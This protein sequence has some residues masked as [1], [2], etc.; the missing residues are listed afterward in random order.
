[1]KIKLFLLISLIF[2]C[3]FSGKIYA[4]ELL[5]NDDEVWVMKVASDKTFTWASF[6]N[7]KACAVANNITVSANGTYNIS[8]VGDVVL[9]Y[10][11]VSNQ[12]AIKPQIAVWVSQYDKDGIKFSA[13]YIHWRYDLYGH[14]YFLS[15]PADLLSFT[16]HPSDYADFYYLML[17]AN[18][19]VDVA[20]PSDSPI[21]VSTLSKIQHMV[22]A[23]RRAYGLDIFT[24]LPARSWQSGTAV[25]GGQWLQYGDKNYNY[26]IARVDISAAKNTV[27]PNTSAA[28]RPQQQ[29]R[30]RPEWDDDD[31][32]ITRTY[33]SG[34]WA[35]SN[36]VTM[37]VLQPVFNYIPRY[38]YISIEYKT[39]KWY[40]A[41]I[42]DKVYNSENGKMV[43]LVD[44]YEAKGD[45]TINSIVSIKL[46]QVIPPVS[47]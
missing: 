23:G 26:H 14:V 36:L 37:S 21:F 18:W 2:L 20:N 41:R 35:R 5:D 3:C 34:V 8:R 40:T 32:S 42:L 45:F 11:S 24:Q 38:G 12:T 15:Y 1:M 16:A 30:F 27:A 44:P 47:P 43:L 31:I 17:D 10:N 29:R 33:N 13:I 22:D 6:A 28:F 25:A 4:Y 39:D 46:S 19:L 9:H 7:V